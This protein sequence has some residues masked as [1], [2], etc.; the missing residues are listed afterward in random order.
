M[1]PADDQRRVIVIPH[2]LLLSRSLDDAQLLLQRMNADKSCKP[3]GPV[4]R[5]PG[6]WPALGL[7]RRGPGPRAD[8]ITDAGP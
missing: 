3:G 5:L 4:S 8:G 2:V 7:G 6:T 1:I